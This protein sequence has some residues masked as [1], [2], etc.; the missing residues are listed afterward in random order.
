MVEF[1]SIVIGVLASVLSD[2]VLIMTLTGLLH[3]CGRSCTARL[4]EDTPGL[5]ALED[6]QAHG[7]ALEPKL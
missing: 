3:M 6:G 2:Q 7:L 4:V 1:Q 5:T